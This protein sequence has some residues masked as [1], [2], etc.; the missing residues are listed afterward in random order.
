MKVKL[1]ISAQEVDGENAMAL[2]I[3]AIRTLLDMIEQLPA[4]EEY[5][6]T[7]EGGELWL[8]S[9]KAKIEVSDQPETG[10][11]LFLT[12]ARL[13]QQSNTGCFW[14]ITLRYGPRERHWFMSN[15]SPTIPPTLDETLSHIRE[16][17]APTKG[18]TKQRQIPDRLGA[19]WESMKSL[20]VRDFAK[21]VYP[22][23]QQ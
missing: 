13:L 2:S 3:R 14:M 22:A 21:M 5:P 10:Y 1:T 20:F 7:F 15:R 8:P 9:A 17:L 4:D 19:D 16:R 6:K 12:D 18:M 23:D 11:T